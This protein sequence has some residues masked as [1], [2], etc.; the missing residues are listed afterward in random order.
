MRFSFLMLDTIESFS[1]GFNLDSLRLCKSLL[2][3][4]LHYLQNFA[5]ITCAML[6]TKNFILYSMY[7]LTFLFKPF[8]RTSVKAYRGTECYYFKS[9][10]NLSVFLYKKPKYCQK[11][12]LMQQKRNRK[13]Q[14]YKISQILQSTFLTP[15]IFKHLTNTEGK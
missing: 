8:P 5:I 7:L 3:H 9:S 6:K 11:R 15:A 1:M 10:I 12:Q 2:I 4:S 14:S 13:K